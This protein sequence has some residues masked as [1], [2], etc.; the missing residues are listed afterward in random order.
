MFDNIWQRSATWR[1]SFSQWVHS[2]STGAIC[3]DVQQRLGT[4]EYF[5]HYWWPVW[6]KCAGRWAV[7]VWRCLHR[8]WGQCEDVRNWYMACLSQNLE[9]FASSA[10]RTQQIPKQLIRSVKSGGTPLKKLFCGRQR[11]VRIIIPWYPLVWFLHSQNKLF[12]VNFFKIIFGKLFLGVTRTMEY[13]FK[14][15][16]MEIH[17]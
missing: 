4:P 17:C 8:A 14:G 11:F 3:S 5:S 2:L 10:L 6:A 13:L 1:P 9:S 15:E 7:C 12:Q 16:A